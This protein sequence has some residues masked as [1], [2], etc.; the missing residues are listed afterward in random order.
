MQAL[1][2]SIHEHPKVSNY[3]FYSS[4][5]LIKQLEKERFWVEKRNCDWTPNGLLMHV[6]FPINPVRNCLL[7]EFDALPGIGHASAVVTLWVLYSR[8]SRHIVN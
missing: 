4:A 5:A 7:A 2:L 8:I 1:A 3:E 6:I